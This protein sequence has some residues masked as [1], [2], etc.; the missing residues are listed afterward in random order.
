MTSFLL[1]TISCFDSRNINQREGRASLKMNEKETISINYKDQFNLT[2]VMFAI[3]S[4]YPS[5]K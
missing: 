5:K 4:I 3:I 1:G 2:K